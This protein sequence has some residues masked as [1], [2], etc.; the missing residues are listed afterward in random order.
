MRAEVFARGSRGVVVAPRS[1]EDETSGCVIKGAAA[2]AAELAVVRRVAAGSFQDGRWA[3]ELVEP[4]QPKPRI[5]D[6]TAFSGRSVYFGSQDQPGGEDGDWRHGDGKE[7]FVDLEN[8]IMVCLCDPAVR[9]NE[10]AVE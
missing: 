6:C 3:I 4:W 5:A 9:F 1:R 10:G 8:V 7:T 2:E